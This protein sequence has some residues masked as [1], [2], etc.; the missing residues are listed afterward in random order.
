M[1]RMLLV[2]RL[3]ARDLRRRSTEAALLFLVLAAAAAT[4][5][6]GLELGS[7][8]GDQPYL[9]TRAATAGPDV[10]VTQPEPGAA[11]LATLT[12]MLNAPNVTGHSGPFPAVAP[13]LQVNGY[14][15]PV[16][17]EGRDAAAASVDQPKLTS[18]SWVSEGG[19]VLERSFAGV[20][21]VGTGDTVTLGGRAFKVVGIA[22]TAATSPYPSDFWGFRRDY[23]G[24][25]PGL[26]WV[27][28]ADAKS[29]ATSAQ[30]A[31]YILNLKL[32]DPADA[33]AFVQQFSP[34]PDASPQNMLG[35]ASWQGT[36]Q[37]VGD[38]LAKQQS[39]LLLAATLL[40]LFALTS[41]TV[42]VG[43]RL[44]EQTRRVGLLRAVG[45]TPGLVAAV[46][47]AE[48][49]IL[50]LLAAGVGLGVGWLAAPTVTDPSAGLLGTV[51]FPPI[52]VST[53]VAVVG[54]AVVVA[55]AA[56]LVPAIRAART[57]LV[58]ALED[59]AR[60]PRRRGLVI[61]LSARM[62]VPMLLGLRMAARRPRRSVLSAVS[63]A[64]TVATVV[65]V[66]IAFSSSPG[67]V[68]DGFTSPT[69]PRNLSQEHVILGFTGV[70]VVLSVINV[71]FITW[72]TALDSRRT[73][74]VARALGASPRQVTAGLAAAQLVPAVAGSVLGVPL[75]FGLFAIANHHRSG[76][77]SP[78]VWLLGGAVVGALV[79][80][81][82]FTAIPARINAR[83][84]VAG[85][86]QA[87]AG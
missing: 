11:G 34:G 85:V 25:G 2:C 67:S 35:L 41:V 72:T 15:L 61:A 63:I 47:L 74:A 68:V 79:V 83:R 65:T 78:S 37:S 75:G 84:P 42:L 20:L 38:I 31:G 36:S 21:G 49:L 44:A 52:R 87:E 17:A 54:L 8:A 76:L 9:A 56:S 81:A 51:G 24:S 14:D 73:L 32:A 57:S 64:I 53:A 59:A 6:L 23:Y 30:P 28:E 77:T 71:V 4:L 33:P 12:P 50:A 80:L 86:L 18:G 62:P 5:S 82:V 10:V 48:N 16:V 46:L 13:I 39:L 43:G 22:V 27:T 1:G 29:L 58:R 19:V 3:V 26:V 66:M 40:S 70:L 45:A 60:S 7:V 55:L 69:A